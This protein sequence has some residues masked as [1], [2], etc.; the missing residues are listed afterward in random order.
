MA[1]AESEELTVGGYYKGSAFFSEHAGSEPGLERGVCDLPHV[2][3]A[4]LGQERLPHKAAQ[5]RGQWCGQGWGDEHTGCTMD[6]TCWSGVRAQGTPSGAI[7]GERTLGGSGRCIHGGLNTDVW[8]SWGS[9]AA[10]GLL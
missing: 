9:S 7:L 6:S 3:T 2:R 10:V 4:F 8:T 5:A 1:S